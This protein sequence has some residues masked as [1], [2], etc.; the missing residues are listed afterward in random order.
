MLYMS[1]INLN[2]LFYHKNKID[3]NYLYILKNKILL[4]CSSIESP[5]MIL[6]KINT[7]SIHF[8]AFNISL[9]KNNFNF[10]INN[11]EGLTDYWGT[12][13]NKNEIKLNFTNYINGN[14]EFDLIFK[15]VS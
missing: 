3:Y 11:Q 13:L 15:K 5:K 10:S 1:E 8:E 4:I 9:N 12:V 6:R 2:G 14:S 7:N